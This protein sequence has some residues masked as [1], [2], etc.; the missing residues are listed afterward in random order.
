[1]NTSDNSGLQNGMS[2][3][4]SIARVLQWVGSRTEAVPVPTRWVPGASSSELAQ[5]GALGEL[6]GALLGAGSITAPVFDTGNLRQWISSTV[7]QSVDP[8]IIEAFTMLLSVNAEQ[9][10][11]ALYSAI[12]SGPSRRTLGT[13][14]T[15][16]DEAD[17]M[18]RRWGELFPPPSRIVDVGAGVGIFSS[19]AAEAWPEATTFAVDINPVTLG[20]LALCAHSRNAFADCP[21]LAARIIPIEADFT[22]WVDQAWK[23][24]PG[25]GLILGNPPYTR[26]QL[27]PLADRERLT[28][29][30]GGLVGSRAALSAVITAQSLL[31]LGPADGLALLLPAQWLEADY[32]GG[33]RRHLWE[34]TQRRVELRI[35]DEQ[36]FADATVDAV[37][38]LV[39]PEEAET[40]PLTVSGSGMVHTVELREA[41]D[42]NG[43][44]R[45]VAAARARAMPTQPDVWVPLSKFLQVRRGVAT[46]A[47]KFFILDKV[48]VEKH[49]LD[50]E[51]LTPLLRR[52]RNAPD[53]LSDVSF[54]GLPDAERRWLLTANA[55]QLR[56]SSALLAYVAAGEE[57]GVNAG[58]LCQRRTDWFDLHHDI[59]IPDII[60]GQSSKSGFRIIENP[61]EAAIANNLYGMRW[62]VTATLP[63]RE[64]IVA[65]LRGPDGQDALRSVA[66]VQATGLLKIEPRAL[67]NLRVPQSVWGSIAVDDEGKDPIRWARHIIQGGS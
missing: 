61:M 19:R 5:L 37:A 64:A 44:E 45:V 33:L 4:H 8:E 53:V 24:V 20:L 59:S 10:L 43:F 14:F 32:A 41:D 50:E 66:R 30:G 9:N 65:W 11:A 15:P 57:A 17:W 56:T 48:G 62:L 31:T 58:L 25:P 67:S 52:T 34:Q 63:Q 36:L 47:N 22:L 27:M 46:G 28:R 3:E 42:V 21:A 51:L 16:R 49:E 7:Q 23:S 60:I 39:G 12:V 55:G 38:L 26:L 2:L 1:M 54:S 13:F 18:V 6:I 29:S 35:F 40:Q